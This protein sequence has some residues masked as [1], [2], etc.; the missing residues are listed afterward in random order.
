MFVWPIAWA[1]PG[2]I[3]TLPSRGEDE[4]VKHQTRR[5]ARSS[6]QKGACCAIRGWHGIRQ[7][8]RF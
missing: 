3:M 7:L 1:M 2:A 4:K 6:A 5:M 8:S